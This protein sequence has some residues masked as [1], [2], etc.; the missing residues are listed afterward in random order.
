MELYHECMDN[1]GWVRVLYDVHGGMEKLTL[2]RK[3]S[4]LQLSL[5]LLNHTSLDADKREEA[6]TRQKKEGGMV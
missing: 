4:L 1:N 3:T 6:D 5:P 2:I